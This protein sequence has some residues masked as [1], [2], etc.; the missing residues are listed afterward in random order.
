MSC[1]KYVRLK[2]VAVP[3]RVLKRQGSV[4]QEVYSLHLKNI[5][6]RKSPMPKVRVA[7]TCVENLL[8]D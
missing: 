2:N 1:L 8:E 6:R 4:K 5:K 3:Y 7:E